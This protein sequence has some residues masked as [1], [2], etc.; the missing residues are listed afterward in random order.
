MHTVSSSSL[1][2]PQDGLDLAQRIGQGELSP[3]EAL[4]QAIER[5]EQ[6]NPA[7]NAVAEKLYHLG[8]QSV[9]Q[10]LPDGP[11]RGVPMLTKDLF[12]P[13]AG[14]R[15]SNGSLLLKDNVMPVDAEL[16]TRL[17]KAGFT[18]FGTTTSPEFG[19]SYTTESRLFGATRNPWSLD[20]SCGGSSGAAAALVAARV[21]PIAH[22]NDGGG[23]LRVPASACGVFGLKPS[24]G[25]MPMGPLA[26]EG[27]AGMSTSHV[28][29]L[30]VRDSAAVLDQL[31]GAD[32][33]APY[34]APHYRQSFLAAA[35]GAAPQGLRIGLVTHLPPWPTHPDCSEAV[36][37]T[38]ALCQQLGHHVEE[39]C[40]PVDGL[41][42]Y[43]TVFTIIGSQTRNLLNLLARM[44]GQPLDEQAL[45]AR[46][47]VIL[48]DKGQLSGADYAAAVDYLHAF[49]RRMAELMQRYD[50]ILTPTMA[51]PPARIGALTVREEQSVA[52][53]IH[54]FHGFSP[55][56]ALCN[57]SGQ[58][59][60]SVPL[61]WNDQGLPIGSHFC[62]GFGDDT[63]LLAVAAQLEQAAPWAHRRPPVCAT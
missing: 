62:A 17:K 40:L 3:G 44:A 31:A 58:P 16:V 6:V 48:R 10:G 45:E 8:E 50:L 25:L 18:I 1:V 14:A 60:M 42:F 63:L 57:A 2:R 51:Q 52:E 56:T 54:T 9:A 39:T 20:H 49:G 5:L 19:T 15:M 7:L 21:L 37:R 38:A 24:R 11:F 53:L 29:S 27:W 28:M 26:G 43:D 55:F 12:T 47:R 41:E 32:L 59:A 30:S 4:A 36:Q 33:G 35:T 23:S 61:H 34:A 13:L 22:G 46:H